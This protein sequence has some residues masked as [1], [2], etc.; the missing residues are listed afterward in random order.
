MD[1]QKHCRT[2][3]HEELGACLLWI[4]FFFFFFLRIYGDVPGGVY[5]PCIL[6]ACQV[7]VTVGNSSLCCCNCVTHFERLCVAIFG[8]FTFKGEI[9]VTFRDIY[10]QTEREIC[11]ASHLA[12]PP[13]F[14]KISNMLQFKT[15]TILPV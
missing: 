13:S 6:H 3:S 11:G 8:L 10:Q 15:N 7:R 14:S 1:N 9:R 5:V 4:N 12:P 2:D